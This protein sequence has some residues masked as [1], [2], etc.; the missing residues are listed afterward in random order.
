MWLA[1]IENIYIQLYKIALWMTTRAL[2][3]YIY[4]YIYIYSLRE[5]EDWLCFVTPR[6]LKPSNPTFFTIRNSVDMLQKEI[7]NVKVV[8][9]GG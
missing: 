8:G 7:N 6:V 3:I 4:I 9:Q 1:Y 5:L 2:H